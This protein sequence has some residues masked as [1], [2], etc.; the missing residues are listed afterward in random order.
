MPFLQALAQPTLEEI[1]TAGAAHS[2]YLQKKSPPASANAPKADLKTFHASIKPI[3]AASCVECHGPD[4]QKAK[5]RV[6]TLDPDLVN[7]KD[8]DWWLEVMEVLSNGEMPP[9]DEDVEIAETDRGKIIDWLSGEIL[10]ASQAKRNKSKHSSFRRM[11]RYEFS[12]ALQDLLGLKQDFVTDL[13][14]EAS[15]EDGFQN[16]SE[17][18]QMTSS[19]FATYRD[20]ARKALITATIRGPQPKPTYFSITM[21]KAGSPYENWLDENI[22]LYQDKIKAGELTADILGRFKHEKKVSNEPMSKRR[23]HFLDRNTGDLWNRKIPYGFSLWKPTDQKPIAPD[24][25]P[26]VLV[27]PDGYDQEIDLGNYLPDSGIM[28]VRVRASRVSAEG[29]SYPSI[30]LSFG[31][32]PNNNSSQ[33]FLISKKDIAITAPPDK[34]EF[35]EWL[36]NMN[37]VQRNSYLRTGIMGKRPTP[38]EYIAIKNVHQGE[39]HDGSAVQIDYIEV[40]APYITQWPPASHLKVFPEQ[41]TSDSEIN[42]AR[43]I[44]TNFMP[45]AWRRKVTNSELER[46]VALFKQIRPTCIDFQETMIE[47]LATVISSPNFL[48]LTQSDTTAKDHELATRLSFFLWSSQPDQELLE[49]VFNGELRQPGV[50]SQQAERMLADPRAERFT[51][52]FTRQWLGM[53]L[54]DLLQVDREAYPSFSNTLKHAMQQEPIEFFKHVLHQD[55]SIMDFLHA[56]YSILNQRLATHYGI[57]GVY[58]NHFR[59]VSLPSNTKRGGLLAQAGFLA[60]NSDG[61]DSH[62]LKRGIWLLEKILHDPPPPPPPAV[63]E[64]DL[65]D[66]E[67]MKMTLKERMEDHRNK[68]ACASC[69]AKIDPWGI[70]FENFDAIGAWRDEINGKPVDATSKLYNKSELSGMYGLKRYLLENRQDQFARA[71]VHK[72]ASYALGRPLSFADRAEVERITSEMRQKGDGMRSL[73]FLLIESNLFQSK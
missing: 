21:D 26:F 64:I 36:I 46:K 37:E 14:P 31:H 51:K 50:L 2:K 22:K 6:D 18:L 35:Y 48:Y 61:R 11:T 32:K 60:M 54:L 70:A 25:N 56:D 3:L 63:P 71:M 7:G 13:P 12:Y 49:L 29:D 4:K 38:T 68:P 19:Q 27:L 41:T 47:V 44:L 40:T 10:A 15:S 5:F 20:I 66:P 23:T 52:H 39:A 69:H 62:P 8:A 58:G 28:R 34:P 1:K 30:S 45:R 72:L 53:E 17:V 42:S 65:T 9:P 67:I 33:E 43:K 55:R 57:T 24:V 16:S 73:L 59:K